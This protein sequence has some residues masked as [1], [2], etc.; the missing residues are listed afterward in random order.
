MIKLLR[1][2]Y[3]APVMEKLCGTSWTQREPELVAELKQ[4]TEDSILPR[5]KAEE[6]NLEEQKQ[7]FIT[8]CKEVDNISSAIDIFNLLDSNWAL[9]NPQLFQRMKEELMYTGFGLSVF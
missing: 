8:D 2:K 4:I 1:I 6:V 7:S 5:V 3:T 9:S